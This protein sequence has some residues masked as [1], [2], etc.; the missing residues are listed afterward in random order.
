MLDL[1]NALFC[2]DLIA[3]ICHLDD[4]YKDFPIKEKLYLRYLKKEIDTHPFVHWVTKKLD[5]GQ[6]I[7]GYNLDIMR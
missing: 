2:K 6:I 3:F 5:C 1:H 4:I 7:S